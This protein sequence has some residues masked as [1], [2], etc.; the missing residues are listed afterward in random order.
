MAD[1][2]RILKL[3]QEI[4]GFA[5]LSNRRPQPRSPGLVLT[6]MRS[7]MLQGVLPKRRLSI[8]IATKDRTD[9]PYEVRINHLKQ[10]PGPA[11][12]RPAP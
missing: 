5:E 3:L 12:T 9:I 4:R 2:I 6:Q 1:K 11:A 10:S 7:H 8:R